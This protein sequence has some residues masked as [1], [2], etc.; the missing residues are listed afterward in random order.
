MSKT[1]ISRRRFLALTGG[2]LGATAVACG[3]LITLGTQQ[4]AIEFTQSNCGEDP[5][6]AD[7]VLIAYA[8]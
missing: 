4:P 6:M 3:G 1:R 5:N 2:A 8:S 7:Q